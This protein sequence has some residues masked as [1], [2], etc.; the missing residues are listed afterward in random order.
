MA[1]T[2]EDFK[3]ARRAL[4]GVITPTHLVYSPAFSEAS[5]NHVYLKPENL[6][7][8]GAYK[9]RGA[10]FK[11]STLTEEEKAILA[12]SNPE[13]MAQAEAAEQAAAQAPAVQEDEPTAAQDEEEGYEE[14]YSDEDEE[15]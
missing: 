10:Y 12:E 8:T 11:C 9:I 6:Q 7:V 15:R 4:E 5:G 3:A 2:L 14:A 1:M 13:L